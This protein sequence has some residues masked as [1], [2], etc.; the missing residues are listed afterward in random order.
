MLAHMN[1]TILSSILIT[2]LAFFVCCSLYITGLRSLTNASTPP[3][4]IFSH[5]LTS[6]KNSKLLQQA[7]NIQAEELPMGQGVY[8]RFEAKQEDMLEFLDSDPGSYHYP[9]RTVSYRE[10]YQAYPESADGWSGYNWWRPQ[11]ITSPECYVTRPYEYFIFD[12][13]GTTVYYYF[14]PD[15]LGRDYFCVES[16]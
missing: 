14:F 4:K 5:Y 7:R 12:K 8:I 3:E 15:F 13:K 11:E 9:Y 6:P 10:F 16:K 1:K 2:V